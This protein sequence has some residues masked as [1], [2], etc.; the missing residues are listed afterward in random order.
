[1]SHTSCEDA[2][3]IISPSRGGVV[4]LGGIVLH[5]L[6]RIIVIAKD[7]SPLLAGL[8]VVLRQKGRIHTAV[9]DLHLWAGTVVAGV[10]SL[11][12]V[13]PVLGCGDDL[14]LGAGAVP[15][16]LL[17]GAGVETSSWDTRVY[18]CGGEEL[19]VCGCHDVLML[20]V[21]AEY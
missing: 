4:R 3:Q 20:L 19:G 12:D 11:G 18:S 14:A 1:M 16:V 10:H 2:L 7:T 8:V 13:G 17:V 15:S 5:L 9:V 21:I 6:R